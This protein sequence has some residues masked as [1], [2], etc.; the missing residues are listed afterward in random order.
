MFYFVRKVGSA[1]CEL[2]GKAGGEIDLLQKELALVAGLARSVT[3]TDILQMGQAASDCASGSSRD[4]SLLSSAQQASQHS[5]SARSQPTEAP[6][7]DTGS[8]NSLS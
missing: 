8:G 6:T 2:S 3:D 4:S 1:V 7:S 5:I